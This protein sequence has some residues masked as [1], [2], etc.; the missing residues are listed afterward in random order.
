MSTAQ[1]NGKKAKTINVKTVEEQ[2][3]QEEIVSTVT[4]VLIAIGRCI[5]VFIAVV[6][7]LHMQLRGWTEGSQQLFNLGAFFMITARTYKR[8]GNVKIKS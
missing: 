5:A 4:K 8:I 6:A 2:Q 3:R 7:L 1:L